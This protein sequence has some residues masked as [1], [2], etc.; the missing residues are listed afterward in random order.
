MTHRAVQLEVAMECVAD[1]IINTGNSKLGPLT[2][3]QQ[4][5]EILDVS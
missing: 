2:D 5:N 1:E 3:G 4:G